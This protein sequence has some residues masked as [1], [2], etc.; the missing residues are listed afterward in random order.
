MSLVTMTLI[1]HCQC[2]APPEH[3]SPQHH[4]HSH[5]LRCCSCAP[6]D[7][8]AVV[9]LV[10]KLILWLGQTVPVVVS[11]TPPRVFQDSP[12]LSSS[13]FSL[14]HSLDTQQEPVNNNQELISRDS[15]RT[16]L[17]SI[18]SEVSI[19]KFVQSSQHM[20]STD[21]LLLLLVADVV[22]LAG[23]Q[24]NELSAAVQNQL[25][26][27]IGHSDVGQQL[28]DH[29]VHGSAGYGQLIILIFISVS[30]GTQF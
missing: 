11:T 21:G 16:N 9:S 27:I 26:S 19:S 24:V 8:A 22:T 15:S 25:A 18:F 5:L 2:P 23:D 20:L 14:L 10:T 6:S 3:W 12:V 28:L 13:S 4:A 30:L 1:H 17:F 7:S 29:L